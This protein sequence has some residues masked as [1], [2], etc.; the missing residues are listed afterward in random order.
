MP[1]SQVFLKPDLTQEFYNVLESKTKIL[2]L[3]IASMVPKQVVFRT[4][5]PI[6][7]WKKLIYKVFDNQMIE[8]AVQSIGFVLVFTETVTFHIAVGS[9]FFR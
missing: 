2:V 9:K 3:L 8:F 6:P 4:F 5:S 7:H 1:D